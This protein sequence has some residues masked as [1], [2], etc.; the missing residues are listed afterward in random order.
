M[1]S[2]EEKGSTDMRQRA[3]VKWNKMLDNYVQPAMDPS[4]KEALDA[5]VAKRKE[6]LPDAWY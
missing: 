6:E 3:F 4:T 1:E 2:W 5:Y